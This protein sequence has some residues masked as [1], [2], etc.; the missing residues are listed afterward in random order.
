MCLKNGQNSLM[1]I[2]KS[3]R[4]P[5]WLGFTGVTGK[6]ARRVFQIFCSGQIK[7]LPN[8]VKEVL[9]LSLLF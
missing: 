7:S 1:Q 3:M 6:T 2:N 5:G 9:S 4:I 8:F